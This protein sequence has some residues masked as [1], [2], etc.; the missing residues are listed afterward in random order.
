MIEHH[1]IHAFRRFFLLIIYM[2]PI[3]VLPGYGLAFDDF[4]IVTP[5]TGDTFISLAAKHL[6]DP[7]KDWMIKDFNQTDKLVYGKK[8]VIPVKP[9]NLGG[10]KPDGY[11]RV[12]VLSYHRFSKTSASNMVVKE[13]AFEE[14]M[15]YL[16]ENG[17]R[18]ITIDQL[19]NFLELKG[20]I[21]EKSILIT[22]DDG[23]R[24][25]YDIAYPILKRYGLPA[26]VFIYTDFIGSSSAMSWEQLKELSQNGFNVQ[27]QS[28][29]HRD[30]TKI[31][32]DESFQKYIR[33]IEEEIVWPMKLIK[34]ELNID[35]KYMAYPYGGYN[36]LVIL[37]LM[38]E[39][40]RGAFTTKRTSNSFFTSNFEIGRSMILG[41]YDLEQFKKNLTV[42]RKEDLK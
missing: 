38:K 19:F 17:Y 14:Q 2:L 4:I 36:G 25:F 18:A 34:K 41:K 7:S 8:L 1:N 26:T 13:S 37:M 27:S 12:P 35:C 40:F 29:T 11:Q 23:F 22:I 33:A 39:G 15:K 30:L 3:I 9:Y 24:S 42:F 20:Q 21:P 6:K 31:K 5:K 28:K 10:L 32:D 16:K